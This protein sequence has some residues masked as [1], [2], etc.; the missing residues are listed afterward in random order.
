M[1][2]TRLVRIYFWS[3]HRFCIGRRLGD[4]YQKCSRY[5]SEGDE[6]FEKY[7]LYVNEKNLDFSY[8]F[9]KAAQLALLYM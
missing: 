8:I 5:I 7:L 1:Q 4:E 6:T 9:Y 3:I 2:V